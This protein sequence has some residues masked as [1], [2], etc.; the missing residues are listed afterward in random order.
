MVNGLFDRF[1]NKR[2]NQTHEFRL[3]GKWTT[4]GRVQMVG[5]TENSMTLQIQTQTHL[6]E[7]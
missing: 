4:I 7:P 2:R 6:M 1:V 3:Q 5:M